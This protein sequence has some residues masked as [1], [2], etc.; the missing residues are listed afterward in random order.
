MVRQ[1][2][3]EIFCEYHSSDRAPVSQMLIASSVCITLWLLLVVQQH[4][5]RQSYDCN[6]NLSI[7]LSASYLLVSFHV[8]SLHAISHLTLTVFIL[9]ETL[10]AKNHCK[11]RKCKVW[12]LSATY[13]KIKLLNI[14][15]VT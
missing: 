6:L 11:G 4:T 13:Y 15:C 5:W 10:K 8:S 1:S 9:M 3:I 12:S 7:D 14:L 2:P